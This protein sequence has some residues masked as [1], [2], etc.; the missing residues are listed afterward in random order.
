MSKGG[1]CA[2]V[3]S[4][5]E[6]KTPNHFFFIIPILKFPSQ[7]ITQLYMQLDNMLI[8]IAIHIFSY[9]YITSPINTIN[10]GTLLLSMAY[11]ILTHGQ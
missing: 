3:S 1:V 10:I 9:A 5:M 11:G 2:C 4:F 7:M 8:C 6:K